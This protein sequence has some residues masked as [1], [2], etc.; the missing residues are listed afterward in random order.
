MDIHNKVALIT[1][2]SRGIGRAIGRRF[3]E[4]GASVAVNYAKNRRAAKDSGIRY[5]QSTGRTLDFSYRAHRLKVSLL[6]L[7]QQAWDCAEKGPTRS[8]Y[9]RRCRARCR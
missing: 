8:R 6:K 2:A 3:A 7:E 4:E 9:R 1:G 5:D